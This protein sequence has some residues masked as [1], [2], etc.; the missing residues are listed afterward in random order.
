MTS[1]HRW[2]L[3]ALTCFAMLVSLPA[4]AQERFDSRRLRPVAAQASSAIQTEHAASI[5]QAAFE[6]HALYTYQPE[7][8]TFGVPGRDDPGRA[9]VAMHTM[10]AMAAV[11]I[12]KRLEL[13]VDLPVSYVRR[14]DSI[15]GFREFSVEDDQWALGGVRAG[16]KFLIAGSHDSPG[17]MA[18]SGD[19]VAPTGD[20]DTY[21]GGELVGRPALLADWTFPQGTTLAANVSYSIRAERDYVVTSLDDDIRVSLSAVIPVHRLVTLVGDVYGQYIFGDGDGRTPA[22]AL[23]GVRLTPGNFMLQAAAGPGFPNSL[24]A[25]DWRLVGSL[26]YA[27]PSKKE[28]DAMREPA[29]DVPAPAEESEPEEPTE[30]AEAEQEDTTE[31]EQPVEPPAEEE[32][33]DTEVAESDDQ[34]DD[35]ALEE[36]RQ[37]QQQIVEAIESRTVQFALES[38]RLSSQSRREL[39]L[40]VDDL[41]DLEGVEEIRISGHA[42]TTGPEALNQRLS[43]ERAES[44]KAY[45][46]RNGVDEELIEV[47]AY[48]SSRPAASND[49][50][51]GRAENRRVEFRIT[52]EVVGEA[53]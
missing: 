19:V 26:G 52:I 43:E 41:N 5:G 49:T 8:L 38:D 44:V 18:F 30:V 45:L 46:V 29:P 35:R 39:A 24:G 4:N 48:G 6:F 31:D 1:F 23:F 15:V 9:T 20:R 21:A 11:G 13:R 22:E 40:V 42:D 2:V 34:A 25:P 51:A 14:G 32:P 16:F 53:D 7:P 28:R 37:R 33:A 3:P 27:L 36:R 10:H 50:R 12:C 47:R 17:H